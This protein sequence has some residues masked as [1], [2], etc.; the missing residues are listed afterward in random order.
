VRP[1]PLGWPRAL[2]PRQTPCRVD[3]S[4]GVHQHPCSVEHRNVVDGYRSW[5]ENE[6]QEAE[7]QTLAYA[8]EVDD[9]WRSRQRPTFRS[10]LQART[11]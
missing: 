10:Y 4:K 1:H 2:H 5:R 6:E 8:T 11:A 7:R 9:Y 3:V